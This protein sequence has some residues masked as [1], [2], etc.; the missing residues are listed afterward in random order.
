VRT[1]NPYKITDFL[2]AHK[3][4][5]QGLVKEA[6]EFRGG[7]IG[8]FGGETAIHVGARPQFM[9]E[10]MNDLFDWV[11]DSDLHPVLKVRFSIMR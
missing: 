10:L 1:F 11:K 9:L 6:G 3:L 7:D 2:E 4:M 8:V 5:T